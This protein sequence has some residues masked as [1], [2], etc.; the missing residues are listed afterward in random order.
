MK[1]EKSNK[2]TVAEFFKLFSLLYAAFQLPTLSGKLSQAIIFLVIL[3]AFLIATIWD[4]RLR[5]NPIF[6]IFETITASLAI[7]LT[8]YL[9]SAF[10]PFL[11]ATFISASINSNLLTTFVT[12]IFI[13]LIANLH[14]LREAKNLLLPANFLAFTFFTLGL[15]NNYTNRTVKSTRKT[16]AAES[17][18]HLVETEKVRDLIEFQKNIKNSSSFR[19]LYLAFLNF[20]SSFDLNEFLIYFNQTETFYFSTLKEGEAKT[21]DIT[22]NIDF[23]PRN[24]PELISYDNK[25]FQK[26][27][28]LP[29]ITIYLSEKDLEDLD[30]TTLKLASDLFAHRAAELYLSE[31]EKQLL[32]RLSTL[33]DT[34]KQVTKDIQLYPIMESAAEAVK[35][36][37]GMQKSIICLCE[38]PEKIEESFYDKNLTIIKGILTEHPE[39]IWVTGFFRAAK[40]ALINKKPV[41]AS[42]SEFSLNLLCVPI[43][44]Q[45]RVFGIVGGITSLPKEDAKKDLKTMEVIAALIGSA[46]A[47]AELLKRRE[48]FVINL[49]R[50][51]IAKDMHDNLIQ[52]LF[53]ILLLI[54]VASKNIKE[55][56]D[57]ASE[58][59]NELKERI[60]QSIRD[61]RE[62]I[63][64]L[65]PKSLSEEGLISALE[66]IIFELRTSERNIVLDADSLPTSIPI[67]VENAILRIVQEACS[68]AIRHGN[69]KNIKIK[70]YSDEDNIHL[71]IIDDGAGFDTS[72]IN[73]YLT[74]PEHM[75][76]SSIVSRVNSLGGKI[77][78]ESIPSKG[79]KVKVVLPVNQNKD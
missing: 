22:K 42:F 64:S 49:E 72:E 75:G 9:K 2:L 44:F 52:S 41:L 50:D 62:M 25:E 73:K 3:T 8:G 11:L 71:T 18:E 5:R 4:E 31:A 48:S 76:I 13:V 10:L 59:L 74:S 26:I 35:K 77:D 21:E 45:N 66:G 46:K 47:N 65:Y 36:M 54:E 70:I 57:K 6:I 51:R 27:S 24:P 68:N 30:Y 23:E 34:S 7:V 39:K 58:V 43:I 38:K 20:I 15:F 17:T 32:S 56:P 16:S 63:I 19:D 12:G 69:A 53:S 28:S 60:Q 67:E 14:L 1:K 78:F 79:T 40:D 55:D 37:T 29:E 33:Y 61:T